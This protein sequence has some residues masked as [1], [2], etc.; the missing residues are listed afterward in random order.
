V[1]RYGRTVL[2]VLV[3]CFQS[4]R[5]ALF[6]VPFRKLV[7]P[8]E[9]GNSFTVPGAVE[10][11]PYFAGCPI[12]RAP[13]FPAMGGTESRQLSG[14]KGTPVCGKFGAPAGEV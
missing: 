11:P 7:I 9:A 3:Y 14:K 5:P 6:P 8:T 13:L 10:G 12:H 1:R 2:L 4:T